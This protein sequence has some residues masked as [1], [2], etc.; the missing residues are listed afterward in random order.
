MMS[1]YFDVLKVEPEQHTRTGWAC[2]VKRD[3]TAWACSVK[4]DRTAWACSVKRAEQV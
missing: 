3:R 2:S 4:R 1:K